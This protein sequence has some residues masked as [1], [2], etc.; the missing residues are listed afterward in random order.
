MPEY[1]YALNE[2]LENLDGEM[3]SHAE[4]QMEVVEKVDTAGN[5]AWWKVCLFSST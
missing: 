2:Y 4:D 5:N 1:V 3:S